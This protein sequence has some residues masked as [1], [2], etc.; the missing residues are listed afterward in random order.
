[1]QEAYVACVSGFPYKVYID[2]NLHDSQI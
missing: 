2:S 1:V